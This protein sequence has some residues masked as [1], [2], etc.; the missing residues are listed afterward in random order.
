MV[1][2]GLVAYGLATYVIYHGVRL[3][4]MPDLPKDSHVPQD[5][6]DRYETTAKHFDQ[7]VDLM[8][9]FMGIGWMRQ[10]LVR[11]ASGHILEASVGTGRNASFYNLKNSKSIT[12]IDQSKEMMMIA[13][14]KFHGKLLCP[15]KT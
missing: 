7:D 4:R 2:G 10:R 5:V 12:M 9:K 11:K 1:L 14:E 15:I 3:Y 13:R 6:S 8:E